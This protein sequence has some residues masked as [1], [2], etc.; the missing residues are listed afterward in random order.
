[1]SGKSKNVEAASRVYFPL[2]E[3]SRKIERDSA[4]RV[5]IVAL[6]NSKKKNGN[7]EANSI[8]FISKLTFVSK[9]RPIVSFCASD[10]SYVAFNVLYVVRDPL[11]K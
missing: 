7:I 3:L 2:P 4:C 1:M 11:E 9:H 10:R 6:A 5:E 8:N